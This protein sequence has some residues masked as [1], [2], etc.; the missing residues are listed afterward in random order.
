MLSVILDALEIAVSL[1]PVLISEDDI[2]KRVC[3]LAEQISHDYKDMG[4]VVLIGVLKAP[5]ETNGFGPG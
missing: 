2:Q 4:D 3:E 5:V 1:P